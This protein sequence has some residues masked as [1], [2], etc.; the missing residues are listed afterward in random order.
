MKFPEEVVEKIE[1]GNKIAAIKELRALKGIGLKEAKDLVDECCMK[2]K[3]GEPIKIDVDSPGQPSEKLPAVPHKPFS[4]LLPA[5]IIISLVWAVINLVEVAG[6]A[7]IVLNHQGYSKAVFMVKN[8]DYS[9]DPEDGVRW[10][11]EGNINGEEIQF[12]DQRIA[13]GKSLGL[14]GL[15]KAFPQN[16]QIDVWY[17]PKV[18]EVLFQ[19]RTLRVLH[20]SPDLLGTEFNRFLWWFKFCF[21]PF[22]IVVFFA[23]NLAPGK[24][25]KYAGEANLETCKGLDNPE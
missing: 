9:S 1:S 5:L 24:L 12:R 11:L 4:P 19:G 6:S 18:T 10:G 16:A 15:R 2:L 14:S 13:D 7:I 22:I 23:R 21:L 25:P 20:Y 8:V 3:N 17:N